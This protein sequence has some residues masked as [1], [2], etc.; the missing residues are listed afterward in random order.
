MIWEQAVLPFL[1]NSSDTWIGMNKAALNNLSDIHNIFLRR[2][3]KVGKS[4]ELSLMYF[5]LGQLLM[6]N[7]IAKSKLLFLKH[8]SCLEEESLARI[9]YE[10]QKKYNLSSL[11]SECKEDLKGMDV[12][13]ID[14]EEMTKGQWKSFASEYIRRINEERLLERIRTS[15]KLDYEVLS[16]EKCE[17]K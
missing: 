4:C 14:M 5:D 13:V 16:K 12:T 2:V 17:L 9:F 7:R 6:P 1:L 3:L 8:I 10:K 15:H 11:L